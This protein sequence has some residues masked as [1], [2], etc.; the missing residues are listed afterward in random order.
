MSGMIYRQATLLSGLSA[1][2]RRAICKTHKQRCRPKNGCLCLLEA[3]PVQGIMQ[4]GKRKL[5]KNHVI[6]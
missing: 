1:F 5:F 4:Q 6:G 3:D 2:Q